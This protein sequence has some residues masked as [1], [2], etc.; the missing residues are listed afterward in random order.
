LD[1]FASQTTVAS[2]EKCKCACS[3]NA[4]WVPAARASLCPEKVVIRSAL[5]YWAQHRPN[6]ED[7]TGRGFAG[8]IVRLGPKPTIPDTKV[9]ITFERR[10]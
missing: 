7:L 6:W 8:G 3:T 4:V 9:E 10:R 1:V 2:Y 5:R